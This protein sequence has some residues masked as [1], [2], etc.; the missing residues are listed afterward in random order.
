[1]CNRIKGIF[2]YGPNTNEVPHRN[3]RE[4]GEVVDKELNKLYKK[5]DT[6][7]HAEQKKLNNNYHPG[8]ISGNL[9]KAVRAMAINSEVREIVDK[10]L[11]TEKELL[12]LGSVREW[13]IES[14][15]DNRDYWADLM[16]QE[17]FRNYR[18]IKRQE[19]ARRNYWASVN[20]PHWF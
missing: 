6:I 12:G 19:E 9:G 13:N 1:M 11:K 17:P 3:T 8:T 4:V 14:F 2:G 5:L 18:N 15:K 20:P 16:A 10:I 7:Y